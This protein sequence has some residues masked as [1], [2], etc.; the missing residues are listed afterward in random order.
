VADSARLAE[1]VAWLE[2]CLT[3]ARQDADRAAREDGHEHLRAEHMRDT[4]GRLLLLDAVAALV[5]GLAALAT[6]PEPQ[7]DGILRS[8]LPLTPDQAAEIRRAWPGVQLEVPELVHL[9][10]VPWHDAPK[11]HRWH[12]CWAH[13]TVV[14]D[15]RRV[16]RCP[17]GAIRS[18][19]SRI[20][21][22]RN[23][24]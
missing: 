7:P 18:G 1:A 22:E 9:R 16:E 21:D 23:T 19:G 5:N 3:V 10:G 8:D 17:C 11:P 2:D 15:G 24:R 12:R 20:W 6:A 13:T 4:T 14:I